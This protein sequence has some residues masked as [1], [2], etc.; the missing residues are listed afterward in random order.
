MAQLLEVKLELCHKVWA[1]Q[2]NSQNTWGNDRASLVN[3]LE[4]NTRLD[5]HPDIV[6]DRR[7][8]DPAIGDLDAP[9]WQHKTDLT[10]TSLG[11]GRLKE[12]S[13]QPGC[14]VRPRKLKVISALT[15]CLVCLLLLCLFFSLFKS[16]PLLLGPGVPLPPSLT[17][18][19]KGSNSPVGHWKHLPGTGKSSIELVK[20]K[21]LVKTGHSKTQKNKN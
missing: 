1:S 18:L 6:G 8:H 7:S 10:K 4:D 17:N 21:A 12:T 14:W 15:G 5:F 19:N 16:P 2:F 11:S 20:R 9:V 3:T 13:I